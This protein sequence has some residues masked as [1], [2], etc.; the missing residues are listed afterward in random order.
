MFRST[1]AVLLAGMVLALAGCNAMRESSRQMIDVFKPSD[2]SMGD[3]EDPWIQ[4]AGVEARGNRPRESVGE[5][6][7]MHNFLTSE[8]ARDIERH[9][10]YDVE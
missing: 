3:V 4:R 9:M 1:P 2:Y 8:K 5:P 10:G 7:A 6:A